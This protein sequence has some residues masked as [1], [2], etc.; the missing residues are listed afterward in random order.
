MVLVI[1]MNGAFSATLKKRRN[2][3]SVSDISSMSFEREAKEIHYR[4]GAECIQ[5][6]NLASVDKLTVQ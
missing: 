5:N 4:A 3:P 2:K 6:L 1:M